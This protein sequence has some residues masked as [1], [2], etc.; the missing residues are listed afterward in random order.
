[1]QIAPCDLDSMVRKCVGRGLIWLI[2]KA[3]S[4]PLWDDEW[5]G[6]IQPNRSRIVTTE[7]ME[8]FKANGWC[9]EVGDNGRIYLAPR[10]YIKTPE[11]LYHLTPAQNFKSIR[12]NGLITGEAANKVHVRKYVLSA[13]HLC[14]HR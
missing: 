10:V 8:Y 5:I 11:F 12:E 2:E 7:I 3:E 9:L 1:M 4:W 13:L 6:L 14:V